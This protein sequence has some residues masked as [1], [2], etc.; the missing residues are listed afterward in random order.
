MRRLRE[1]DTRFPPAWVQ[2]IPSRHKDL[3]KRV[4]AAIVDN[5]P[6][7]IK[8]AD[9][10]TRAKFV[11]SLALP[12]LEKRFGMR[13]VDGSSVVGACGVFFSR[14]SLVRFGR[15]GTPLINGAISA[16]D[17]ASGRN[18][19][20]LWVNN[21]DILRWT[22]QGTCGEWAS[23]LRGVMLGAGIKAEEI[24]SYNPSFSF[25]NHAATAIECRRDG[26][27]EKRRL[28][29]LVFG[30]RQSAEESDL[31]VRRLRGRD[32]QQAQLPPPSTSGS[33]TRQRRVAR[34]ITTPMTLFLVRTSTRR[35][36]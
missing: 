14:R 17:W 6:A 26:V 1:L 5:A 36:I 8:N 25:N 29:R 10:C 12:I 24:N 18:S 34:A 30:S 28:R 35:E 11:Y 22:G 4:G 20:R 7:S 2:E 15:L 13:Q 23:G 32:G 31:L 19:G 21:D 3:F 9:E 16:A 27:V 33:A